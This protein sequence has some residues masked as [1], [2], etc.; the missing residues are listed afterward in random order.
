MKPINHPFS[1]DPTY[2]HSL[3]ELLA[4]KYSESEPT[5]FVDFWLELKRK[6]DHTPLAIST[7]EV[8]SPEPGFRLLKVFYS[9]YPDYRVGAWMICPTDLSKVRFGIVWG[10]GYGGRE[11]P[12]WSKAAPDRIVIF[13]VAPGFHISAHSCIPLNDSSQHVLH[14]IDDKNAYV[15]G[16][17][18]CALWRA[19]DVLQKFA[20]QPLEQFHYGGWSFGGGIGALML[21]WEPRYTSAELGQPT[22]GNHSFRLQSECVGSGESVRRLFSSRPEIAQTLAFFDSANAAR[23]LR[24]PVVFACATFDPVVPP[25]GQFSVASSHPGPKRVSVFLTGH[26]SYTHEGSQTEERLLLKNL[27]EII[28]RAAGHH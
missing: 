23:H 24:I 3:E 1:F 8:P 11:G 15:L 14:G 7:Q 17:C 25:P 19:V 9:I 5:G 2:G 10:H 16:P 6:S 26:F 28:G 13:P 22:F 20:P 12:E 21:P 27:R 18:A 4:L